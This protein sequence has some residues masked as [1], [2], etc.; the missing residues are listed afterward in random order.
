VGIELLA[1][2]VASGRV[3]GVDCS[4][5]M[6]AQATARNS[7]AIARRRVD[8]RR[9]SVERLPFE[10]DTFQ[11]ARAINSLQVWPDAIAG[12]REVRRVLKGGGTLA[13]GFTPHSGQPRS[14][15]VELIRAAGFT[16]AQLVAKEGDFCALARKP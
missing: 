15:L 7:Q 8:L 1:Q 12:L 14:G 11:K 5:E 6:L 13:L 10:D 9:G 16:G 3:A 2:A 4:A